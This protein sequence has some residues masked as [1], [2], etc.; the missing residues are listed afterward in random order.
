MP[1][2][3]SFLSRLA[4]ALPVVLAAAPGVIDAI[5]QAREALRGPRRPDDEPAAPAT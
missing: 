5:R 4:R 1:R 2:R 3:Q